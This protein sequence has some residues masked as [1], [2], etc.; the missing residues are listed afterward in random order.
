[1]YSL[2]TDIFTK[3]AEVNMLVGLYSCMLQSAFGPLAP[4][5]CLEKFHSACSG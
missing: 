4:N 5:Y 1:M 3:M 2:F